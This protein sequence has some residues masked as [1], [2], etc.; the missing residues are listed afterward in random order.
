MDTNNYFS[1]GV[2]SV[3]NKK[4]PLHVVIAKP[5][6]FCN[7]DCSYCSSP[8]ISEKGK[9]KE[10]PFW[11]FED[12][13]KYFDK[14]FPYMS[15]GAYWIWHGGEPMLMGIEF[16]EKVHIYAQEKMHKEEKKIYFSM[17]TNLIGYNSKWSEIFKKSFGGIISTSYDASGEYR[18][19]KG[20]AKTY[21]RIFQRNMEH[22]IEDGVGAMVIGVYDE[23]TAKDMIKMY[24]W[25]KKLSQPVNLR[26]NYLHPTGRKNGVKEMISPKT[27]ADNLLKIY[28]L[29]L[30]DA[31][32]FTVTPMDQMFQK[33]LKIDADGHCPWIKNCG[34]KFIGIEPDGTIFNC[35]DF[36]D[37]DKSYSF[38][39][40][41]DLSIPELLNSPQANLIKKR[42]SKLPESCLQCE[43]FQ[44][45]EGGCARDSVLFNQDLYGKFHYCLSWKMVYTRIKASIL[46][47]QADKI[48]ERYG[49]QP[50]KVKSQIKFE[51]ETHFDDVLI[52]KEK[53]QSNINSEHNY[54][55]NIDSFIKNPILG[56]KYYM[57]K[58]NEE[59]D[60]DKLE[61]N[62]FEAIRN[63]EKRKV[64]KF[65]KINQKL[66]AIKI[67]KIE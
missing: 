30:Q 57:E 11:N 48:I 33:T 25:N 61:W 21:E 14:V 45:C 56:F 52:L 17:Q 28:D 67:L 5:T 39:N 6:R 16:Y 44:E 66:S 42:R 62:D 53:Q 55:N 64:D 22:L 36:A 59:K 29:W 41:N 37:M 40:L 58:Y 60:K 51:I 50:E 2:T 54:L 24:E 19:I 23:H 31:P 26:F 63:N 4:E 49:L 47:G 3:K 9:W 38:G 18:T 34:G 65:E 13:V 8:P 35:S 43:H 1:Y 15:D 27:Y 10:E 20:N 32:D 7:A 46:N 12:F